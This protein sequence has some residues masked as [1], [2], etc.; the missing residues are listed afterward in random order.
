MVD[1]QDSKTLVLQF[2]EELEAAS[3][4]DVAK[5]MNRYRSSDYQFRGVHPF[6]ESLG[7]RA[8]VS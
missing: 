8:F 7:L 1:Y 2:Y 5:V 4:D 6:F 3:A